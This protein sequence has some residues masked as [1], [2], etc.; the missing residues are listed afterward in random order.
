M[1]KQI[2]TALSAAIL[3]S[4]GIGTSIHAEEAQTFTIGICQFVQHEAL[5]AATQGFKDALTEKLGDR[6]I[7]DIQNAQGDP[8]TCTTV[9]NGLIS[10]DVDLILA[11]STP[12]L[13]AAVTATSEVP[14]LGTS[15]TDYGAA[16]QIDDFDGIAGGNVSGTSDLA[17][18][19]EQAVMV[20]ELF[21][22]AEKI[23]LLY[24]SAEPNSQHQ[25][26]VIKA[27]L[28]ALGYTCSS[29]TFSDSNDISAAT[30][31]A[32]SECDVLYVP[33]DNTVASNA[34]LLQNICVPEKTPVVAGEENTC[35]ICGVATLSINYYDLGH[36][37][38]EMAVRILEDG[39]S[40]S[41]MPIEYASDFTKS[42]NE[43]ICKKLDIEIPDDYTVLETE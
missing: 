42:Y 31:T 29:Y 34:E 30:I 16:L 43:S 23:G 2:F 25:I 4:C 9:I 17:P 5:D 35:K 22:E 3:I 27:E 37:T 24:C 6:V 41:E 33:T 21:P 18:L 12:S 40:I 36:T 14:I 15:V 20:K 7:F 28:E 11:N 10:K 26:D 13:Q 38:G 1:K 32:V 39:E 19:G 8:A